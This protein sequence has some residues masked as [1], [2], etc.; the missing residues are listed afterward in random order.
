MAQGCMNGVILRDSYSDLA[1]VLSGL[2]SPICV[3]Y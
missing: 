3:K 1:I 2:I